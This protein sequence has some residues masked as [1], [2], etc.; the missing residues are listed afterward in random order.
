MN[1]QDF[2]IDKYDLEYKNVTCTG[3]QWETK[4]FYFT[5]DKKEYKFLQKEY[6]DCNSDTDH[7]RYVIEYQFLPWLKEHNMQEE[8]ARLTAENDNLTVE[9]EVSQRDVENLTRTLDEANDE[10]KALEA[11]NA[12][13]KKRLENAVELKTQVGDTLYMP[14]VYNG[15]YDIAKLQ[16]IGIDF[17]KSEV[18]YITDLQSDNAYY[19]EKYKLG[20][21]RNEDF[22]NMV[23]TDYDKAE[24]KLK[25]IGGNV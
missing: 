15:T 8:I 6:V 17:R 20:I 22:D 12:E 19:L 10:I 7:I 9:L 3:V 16:I 5:I 4:V 13:L 11:E 21:F 18:V 2:E 14:W 23:F 1:E 24:I 25:E